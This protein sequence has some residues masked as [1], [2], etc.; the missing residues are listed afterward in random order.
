MDGLCQV[1]FATVLL[2]AVSLSVV[3]T[4]WPY[5]VPCAA[6]ALWG[7]GVL[8]ALAALLLGVF[9]FLTDPLLGGRHSIAL[10]P[11]DIA[12]IAGATYAVAHVAVL[13]MRA[14][15]R[16][17]IRRDR[18]RSLLGMFGLP[19]PEHDVIVLPSNE[20]VAYSL[21]GPGG[22]HAVVSQALVDRLGP[23]ELGAVLAHE[24]AHLR[25]RHHLFV[26]LGEAA[27]TALPGRRALARCA[28]RL[29]QLVEM[30]AD[31]SARRH[32]CRHSLLRAL[33]RTVPAG[34]VPD[35]LS[36]GHGALPL[37]REHLLSRERCCRSV[38]AS[39]VYS[40]AGVAV[41][42]PMTILSTGLLP[43]VCAWICV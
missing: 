39:V 13:Y 23:A 35:A 4:R 7:A 31:C 9:G 38:P 20:A 3:P 40:L 29:G 36:A 16:A 8:G 14:G 11:L 27:R 21:P 1:L 22:G 18:H 28:Q 2:G 26:Q 41:T 17:R 10:L 32:S 15:R 6:L 25:Q 34:S 33:E 37:R 42:S 5:R 30:R 19:H 12:A 24:R 43:A